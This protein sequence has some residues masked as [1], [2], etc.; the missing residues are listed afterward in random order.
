MKSWLWMGAVGLNINKMEKISPE[1][2]SW[3]EKALAQEGG[4]LRKF[5]GRAGEAANVMLLITALS[6]A[7]GF[8]R[9]TYAEE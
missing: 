4:L 3:Q 9:E 6:A 5:R 7:P 1:A 2:K 8:V